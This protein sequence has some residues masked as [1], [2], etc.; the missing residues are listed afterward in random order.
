MNEEMNY[1]CKI[2]YF[3][4]IY[5]YIYI[6]IATTR[7]TWS[8]AGS[9]YIQNKSEQTL[10]ILDICGSIYSDR[11]GWSTVGQD[12]LDQGRGV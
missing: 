9:Y 11:V 8:M 10:L 5:I 3:I 2:T 12:R 1:S 4:Y 7:S 6:Y